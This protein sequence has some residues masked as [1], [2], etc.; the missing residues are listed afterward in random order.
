MLCYFFEDVC[1]SRLC[2]EELKAGETCRSFSFV[3]KETVANV[4]QPCT[5]DMPM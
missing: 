3:E 1:I 4:T 2:E 5:I